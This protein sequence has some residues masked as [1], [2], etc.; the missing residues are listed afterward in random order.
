MKRG[1]L[2]LIV[3][4]ASAPVAGAAF[5]GP[6]ASRAHRE[7]TAIDRRHRRDDRLIDE[8]I[9]VREIQRLFCWRSPRACGVADPAAVIFGL[10]PFGSRSTS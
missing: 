2:V 7:R 1:T 5:M 8:F 10:E 4:C 9:S 3:L 6:I